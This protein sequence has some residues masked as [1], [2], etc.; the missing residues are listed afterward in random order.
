VYEIE[1][2]TV[3]CAQNSVRGSKASYVC[4]RTSRGVAYR[5]WD[6]G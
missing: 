4:K 1:I 3:C 6:S 2:T 5:E